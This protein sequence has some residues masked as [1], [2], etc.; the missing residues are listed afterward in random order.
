MISIILGMDWLTKHDAIK[1]IKKGCEAYLAYILNSQ[2]SGLPPIRD[3]QFVIELVSGTTPILI[4]PYKMAPTELKRLKAQLHELLDCGC[5]GIIREK[6]R[7]NNEIV[8]RLPLRVKEQ[9][10]LKTAF[11]TRYDHYEFLVMSFG[12]RNVLATFM[13]LMNRVFQPYLDRFVRNEIDHTEHLRIELQ[14]LC[15]KI[16][17][18]KIQ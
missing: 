4:A 10:I 18:Y 17:I 3:V 11:R 16:S 15:E 13:D 8:H 2:L 6:E 9:D 14:T 7:R 1:L 12:L 5:T